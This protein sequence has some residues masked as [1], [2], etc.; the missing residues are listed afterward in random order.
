MSHT[1]SVVSPT[2]NKRLDVS[3]QTPTLH[4][5]TD[6]E[7]NGEKSRTA[8]PEKQLDDDS[9]HYVTGFKMVSMM[10]S[11]TIATFLMLLDMSIIVTV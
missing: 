3:S 5:A 10:A 2:D 8:T 7:E 9:Q 11:V 4:D 1:E 6:G